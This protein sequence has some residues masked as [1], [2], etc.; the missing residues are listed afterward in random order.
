MTSALFESYFVILRFMSMTIL[1][2]I[3]SPVFLSSIYW[4]RFTSLELTLVVRLLNVE[5]TS[6]DKALVAR[7]LF[8]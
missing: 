2:I 4:L 3:W 8:S 5:S 6:A 1:L 7:A